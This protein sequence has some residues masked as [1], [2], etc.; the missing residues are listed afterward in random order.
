MIGLVFP[1]VVHAEDTPSTPA[2]TFQAYEKELLIPMRE[3]FEQTINELMKKPS[4]PTQVLITIGV[5]NI[6]SYHKKATKVCFQLSQCIP[7]GNASIKTKQAQDCQ[8]WITNEMQSQKDRI[9]PNFM[10]ADASTKK[11]IFLVNK[12]KEINKQFRDL[13]SIVIQIKGLIEAIVKGTN[14]VISK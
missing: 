11:I 13:V 9:F 10:V 14:E 6:R 2:C 7:E 4:T 3:K 1:S 5:E 12:Y 8:Q